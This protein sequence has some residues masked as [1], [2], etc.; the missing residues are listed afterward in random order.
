MSELDVLEEMQRA[1]PEG[2][3][4]CCGFYRDGRHCTLAGCIELDGQVWCKRHAPKDIEEQER[5]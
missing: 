3:G 4:T 1:R 5:T 2:I